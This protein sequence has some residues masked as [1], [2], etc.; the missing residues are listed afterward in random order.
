VVIVKAGKNDLP[1]QQLPQIT[2]GK[3]VDLISI[4]PTITAWGLEPGEAEVLSFAW[5]NQGDRVII[6]DA[7]ARR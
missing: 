6:D 3:R 2:W 1:S 4:S 7:A 5:E